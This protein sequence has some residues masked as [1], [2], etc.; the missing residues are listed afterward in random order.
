MVKECLLKK[1]NKK[2]EI[3]VKIKIYY[4]Q[5]FFSLHIFFI[6]FC[7]CICLCKKVEFEKIKKMRKLEQKSRNLGVSWKLQKSGNLEIGQFHPIDMKSGL[8][9]QTTQLKTALTRAHS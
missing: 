8:F 4:L 5:V 2:V 3:L 7:C 9:V 6:L 1:N